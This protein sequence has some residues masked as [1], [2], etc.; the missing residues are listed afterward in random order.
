MTIH[1]YYYYMLIFVIVG[2]TIKFS[3]FTY[4][5]AEDSGALQPALI[6]SNPLSCNITI[7]ILDINGTS[8]GE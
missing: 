5:A 7:E 4:S 6:L 1:Y 3:Q 8:A 2:S